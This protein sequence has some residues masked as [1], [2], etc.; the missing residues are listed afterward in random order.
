MRETITLPITFVRHVSR[1]RAA[2]EHDP[3]SRQSRELARLVDN[4]LKVIARVL[5][6][7]QMQIEE[8]IP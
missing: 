4:D 1:L 3:Q 6:E 2:Q 7:M 5:A 8:E